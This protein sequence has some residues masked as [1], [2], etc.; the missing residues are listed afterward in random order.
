MK[1]KV[2]LKRYLKK[3][4]PLVWLFYRTELE[5]NISKLKRSNYISGLKGKKAL[6]Y[7]PYLRTDEIQ[8]CI[9]FGQKYYENDYLDFL[10]DK[11]H[12]GEIS[13]VL[14][15]TTLLDIGS[16]VGNHSLYF[17]LEK[18]AEFA[19]IF[20]PAKDTFEILKKNIEINHLENHTKL[21]N[22]GVGSG[23]GKA[24]INERKKNTA[25]TQ[26]SLS[27][28]GDTD[29]ISIDSLIIKEKIGFV[30]ID[31][32]GF[33]LEVIKGMKE[34]LRRDKPIMMIEI[35][36]KNLSEVTS[37]LSSIGYTLEMMED[38]ISQGDYVCFVKQ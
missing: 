31:V 23:K 37:I 17:I 21:Y 10:C 4:K 19:Y 38:R 3:I 15:G 9:Y 24:S 35:W 7:F 26:L 5:W 25:Y 1:M 16:N 13:R 32:E 8:K 12:N 36:K 34:T 29:V 11:W 20:E 2:S 33:E 30:K 28:E 27:D 18:G 14:K 22:V 6:F